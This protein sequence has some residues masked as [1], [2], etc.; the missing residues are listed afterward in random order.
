MTRQLRQRLEMQ[1]AIDLAGEIQQ[2][3]LPQKSFEGKGLVVSGKSIYCDETGGD[4]YDILHYPG[5]D[6]KVGIAVGDVVGHGIGAALL[7]T[8]VRALLRC[9]ISRSG[10]LGEIIGDVNE[11]LCRDT[12]VTGNFVTLFYMVVD[13]ESGVASWVRGGHEPAIV[14]SPM[15]GTFSELKGKGVALGVDAGI[16][17]EYN[18]ISLPREEQLILIGSDGAWEIENV[19]GEQ[20][21]KDRLKQIVAASSD[22]H[23][24]KILETIVNEIAIF[25]G[26]APQSD[27][28]TLAVIK[29]G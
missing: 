18:E 13:V 25:R 6:R 17:Y 4:F 22:A 24:E 1:K 23:P 5:S 2:N 15:T 26:T 10:S 14:Y 9:R 21:G 20:F 29:T 3:L 19:G 12:I 11:L 27:D 8:T 16:K 7:M 28:I